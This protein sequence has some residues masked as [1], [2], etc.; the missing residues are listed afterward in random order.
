M[1]VGLESE[2]A[3]WATAYVSS[4][5]NIYSNT[6]PLPRT[7]KVWGCS[8]TDDFFR[9]FFVGHMNGAITVSFQIKYKRDPSAAETEEIAGIV[10]EF[11]REIK[12]LFTGF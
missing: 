4:M 2:F 10:E 7:A 8:S 9:G 6:V 3:E 5:I 1:A 12:S 11:N